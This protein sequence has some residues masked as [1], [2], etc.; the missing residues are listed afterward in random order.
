MLT[1]KKEHFTHTTNRHIN[2]F[3]KQYDIIKKSLTKSEIIWL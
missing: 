3:L 2:K 1:Q